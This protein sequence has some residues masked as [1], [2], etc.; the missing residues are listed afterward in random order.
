VAKKFRS[1]EN[2]RGAFPS[3]QDSARTA[4]SRSRASGVFSKPH[5]RFRT[6]HMR[7]TATR[8]E[9]RTPYT[10]VRS[11]RSGSQAS[12]VPAALSLGLL[13]GGGF[14][15]QAIFR[16][17]PGM[18][19]TLDGSINREFAR[20]QHPR[21]SIVKTGELGQQRVA[22][23][24]AGT[25]NRDFQVAKRRLRVGACIDCGVERDREGPKQQ[26]RLARSVIYM[27]VSWIAP[28]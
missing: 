2:A 21:V 11:S 18:V 1:K 16:G 22:V 8:R 25:P 4:R 6:F 7:P 19:H 28:N 12:V 15:R 14:L 3:Q 10:C 17:R 9:D 24:R 27:R 5:G 26:Q 13:E 23:G 20:L